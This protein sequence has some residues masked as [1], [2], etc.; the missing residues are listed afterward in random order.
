ML[1]LAKL[2]RYFLRVGFFPIFDDGNDIQE[3]DI[4]WRFLRNCAQIKTFL[5]DVELFWDEVTLLKRG[6]ETQKFLLLFNFI[7]NIL[8]LPYYS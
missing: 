7:L 8:S 4:E 3:I 2:L 6:D 1:K 5:N